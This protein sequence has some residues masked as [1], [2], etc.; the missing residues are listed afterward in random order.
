MKIHILYTMQDGAWGGGNQFLRALRDE[1]RRL[2]VYAETVAEAE[3]VLCNS[4]HRLGEALRLKFRY[5][6]KRFIHRLGP[7]FRYHRGEKWRAMDRAIVDVAS[8][9]SELVVWQSEWSRRQADDFPPA[10]NQVIIG[11][12]ADPA[13]FYVDKNIRHPHVP[14]VR[15]LATS[16]SAN[17]KKGFAC[18]R[19]LDQTLDFNRYEMTFVGNAS[20]SFQHIKKLPPLQS[21]ELARVINEHDIFVSGAADDACSNAIIE[22]LACGLP[23]VAFDSG[24]SREL[25][26][27]GG[28]LFG[29]VG[30]APA[31]ID[32]VA[33]NYARYAAQVWPQPI[34]A[35]AQLYLRAIDGTP[36][37]RRLPF[38]EL[39]CLSAEYA[40][41]RLK[42]RL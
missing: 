21:R 18:Y 14:L 37:A 24:G 13:I 31:K 7:V 20:G 2:G 42:V 32:L 8:R 23:V 27:D 30:E 4:Y 22:A 19:F 26:G 15:L 38:G 33:D 41:A 5:P 6:H 25:V 40:L 29:A 12:A 16:W 9:L 28:E 34:A 35:V 10:K 36:T 1:F 39:L 11:N 17:S 3:A